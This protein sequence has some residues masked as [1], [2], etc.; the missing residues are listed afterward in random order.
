MGGVSSAFWSSSRF[1][2]ADLVVLLFSHRAAAK[3]IECQDQSGANGV[4]TEYTWSLKRV[5]KDGFDRID[6]Y[7]ERYGRA[8][9]NL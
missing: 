1:S 8:L 3:C 4:V 5:K 2:C 7:I 9:A 6:R